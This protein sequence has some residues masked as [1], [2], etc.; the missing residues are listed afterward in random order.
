MGVYKFQF[1]IL[2]F[3]LAIYITEL[4]KLVRQNKCFYVSMWRSEVNA[5]YLLYYSST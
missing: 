4:S 5:L 2:F 3:T 1:I